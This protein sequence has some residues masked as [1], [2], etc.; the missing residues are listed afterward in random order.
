MGPDHDNWTYEDRERHMRVVCEYHVG[1]R[2]QSRQGGAWDFADPRAGQQAMPA[3][4]AQVDQADV[5]G[6]VPKENP[7]ILSGHLE[8]AHQ[9]ILTSIAHDSNT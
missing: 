3:L 5:I 9:R 6:G 7:S 1:S 2:I 8:F 4:G